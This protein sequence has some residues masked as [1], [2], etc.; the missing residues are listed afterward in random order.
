MTKSN[1]LEL[2]TN[3]VIEQ[4][5]ESE[6]QA[7]PIPATFMLLIQSTSFYQMF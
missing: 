1:R 4:L 3:M 6:M 7:K 2:Y 5:N